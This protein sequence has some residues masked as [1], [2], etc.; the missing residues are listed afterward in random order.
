MSYQLSMLLC[1]LAVSTCWGVSKGRIC[2]LWCN[3][4]W[5]PMTWEWEW[6]L[7]SGSSIWWIAQVVSTPVWA[8]LTTLC[9]RWVSYCKYLTAT[10]MSLYVIG[11]ALCLTRVA[12]GPPTCRWV[13]S[14]WAQD[15][16]IYISKLVSWIIIKV[17]CGQ[18]HSYF[19]TCSLL[20]CVYSA[21][22]WLTHQQ[23]V[24]FISV[25][26]C[27]VVYYRAHK[28]IVVVFGERTYQGSQLLVGYQ[29]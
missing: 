2:L 27:T 24:M 5:G 21:R 22:L 19:T 23:Q 12:T 10:H 25:H 9:W 15:G 7:V 6:C 18:D 26:K 28:C 3:F 29:E 4:D 17:A 1:G 20:D 8:L 13:L 16:W 14:C 11:I